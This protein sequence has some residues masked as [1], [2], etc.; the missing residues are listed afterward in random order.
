MT[1]KWGAQAGRRGVTLFSAFTLAVA[2][3]LTGAVTILSPEAAA[4]TADNRQITAVDSTPAKQTYTWTYDS[5]EKLHGTD[6][7]AMVRTNV[8]YTFGGTYVSSKMKDTAFVTVGDTL[9]MNTSTVGPQTN[10]TPLSE[11]GA[12]GSLLGWYMPSEASGMTVTQPDGYWSP[13]MATPDYSGTGITSSTKAGIPI[14][15]LTGIDSDGNTIVGSVMLDTAKPTVDFAY[16]DVNG[17][18]VT[19]DQ[20]AALCADD[21]WATNDTSQWRNVDGAIAANTT[22]STG[23]A[24]TAD[25][26]YNGEH[27]VPTSGSDHPSTLW[28]A[29]CQG[30]LVASLTWQ[31]TVATDPTKFGLTDATAPGLSMN[32]GISP[33]AKK[34]FGDALAA[35]SSSTNTQDAD[36]SQINGY[37]SALE[38]K[39]ELIKQVCADYKDG[40]PTC[41]Q[42]SPTGWVVDGTAGDNNGDNGVITGVGSG[43]EQGTVPEGV[44][45]LLWRVI[46]KNTGNLPLQNVRVAQDLINIEPAS[47]KTAPT[48]QKNSCV[49]ASL[50][51]SNGWLNNGAT[52]TITCTTTLDGP[53]SGTVQNTAA[54]NADVPHRLTGD[55]ARWI[56]T[57]DSKGEPTILDNDPAVEWFADRFTGYAD[58]NGTGAGV[59]GSIASNID[60]AQVEALNADL[61]LTKYV[62]STG[63]GCTVPEQGT[64][65]FNA[66]AGITGSGTSV[67]PVAGKDQATSGPHWVK[68]TSVAY[69]TDAQWLVIATNIGNTSLDHILLTD[70]RNLP[71]NDP[72]AG[73]GSTTAISEYEG[74]LAPGQSAVYNFTTRDITNINAT[75]SGNDG[76]VQGSSA[77]PTYFVGASGN[78][79]PTRAADV[80][81]SASAKADAMVVTVNPDNTTTNTP[82]YGLDGKQ[83]S[84]TSNSSNAEVNAQLPAP[85]LKET[86]WVC[87]LPAGCADPTADELAIM[88]G[89]FNKDADP[90]SADYGAAV[91]ANGWAKEA[92]LP[93]DQTAQWLIVVKNV[94]DTVI[95]NIRISDDQLTG[96]SATAVEGLTPESLRWLVPGQAGFFR[97]T[98][99]HITN[100]EPSVTG[101]SSTTDG[102]AAWHEPTYA[103]GKDVV[104]T[105]TAQGRAATLLGDGAGQYT[106]PIPEPVIPGDPN[107]N[108]DTFWMVGSNSSNAEVNTEAVA[109]DLKL[110][111][112]VCQKGTGCALPTGAD[113]DTLA[114][115][116]RAADGSISVVKG[117]TALG[118]VEETSVPYN[119]GAQWLVIVTNTGNTYLS[120][121]SV[122]DTLSGIAS[123]DLSIALTPTDSS[124]LRL[125]APGA[126]T[127]LQASTGNITNTASYET[128]DDGLPQGSSAEPTR[129]TGNDVVNVAQASGHVANSAGSNLDDPSKPG[130]SDPWSIDSNKSKAEVNA[131]PIT[132]GVDIEKCNDIAACK[133]GSASDHDSLE[134]AAQLAVNA[135][136]SIRFTITNKGTE[137]LTNVVVSDQ[138]T[139]GQAAD[140]KLKDLSCDFSKADPT[141]PTSGLRWDGGA[142]GFMP[143]ATFDCTGTLRGLPGEYIHED[144][145]SVTGLGKMTAQPVEDTD[146]WVGKTPD[147]PAIDI[148]KW[149]KLGEDNAITGDYD[150]VD[151]AK[152]LVAGEATPIRFTITNTGGEALRDIVVTDQTIN[153]TAGTVD[154]VSCD[155]SS[156]DPTAPQS[157]LTWDGGTK[158]FVAGASFTCTGVLTALDDNQLHSDNATVA[159]V[160][161]TSGEKVNDEDPWHGKT[162][163]HPS[164]DLVKY[165]TSC[166]DPA[167][168]STCQTTPEDQ[169]NGDHN[170][171]AVFVKPGDVTPIAFDFTNNGQDNL[172]NITLTDTTTNGAGQ[173]ENIA[174]DF[175][176][177]K[178]STGAAGPKAATSWL[179]PYDAEQDTIVD[180]NTN[181]TVDNPDYPANPSFGL[182]VG[183]KVSCVGTLTLQAGDIHEDTATISATGV[184]SGEPVKD[185]DPWKGESVTPTIELQKYDT[186]CVT[187]D[188]GECVLDEAGQ[189]TS[190]GVRS[191]D[192]FDFTG[193]FDE[194][195]AP[196]M[197][198]ADTDIPISMTIRNNGTLTL[199]NIVVTDETTDGLGQVQDLT[200]DFTNLDIN[201]RP[202]DPAYPA[203]SWTGPFKPGDEFVCSG[204]LAEGDGPGIPQ[205]Q[206]HSD[207]AS[208][209]GFA[210]KGKGTTEDPYQP[211]KDK[212]VHADDPWNAQTP[213]EPDIDL[214]K[215]DTLNGDGSK[216]EDG[217]ID[218][219]KGD[220]DN[221]AKP[222]VPN[223]PTPISFDI[224]NTGSEPLFDIKLDEVTTT[225]GAK[226][227]DLTCDFSAYKDSTGAVGPKITDGAA[228]DTDAKAD[229]KLEWN[230]PYDPEQDTIVDPNTHETVDNPNYP[231]NPVFGL[232]PGDKVTCTGTLDGLAP[233][234]LH[235]DNAT[236]T[237]TGFG[238]GD[239]VTDEDPWEADSEDKPGIDIEKYDTLDGDNIITGDYDFESS[240]K[241]LATDK[242]TPIEFEITNDGPEALVDIR[243]SDLTTIGDVK[244][245][246]LTCDFSKLGGPTAS[247]SWAEGPFNP[248]DSFKCKAT[249][250]GLAANSVHADTAT[251]TGVGQG[252]GLPVKAEDPW[253][254]TTEPPTEPTTEA[255]SASLALTKWVCAQGM[256]CSAPS[257]ADLAKLAAGQAAG[258]WVK[259]TTVKYNNDAEWLLVVTNTGQSGL[260]DVKVSMESLSGGGSGDLTG[261]KVSDTVI[262]SLGV[263]NSAAF[264]GC[265]APKVTNTGNYVVGQETGSDV[266]NTAQVSGVPTDPK[267]GAILDNPSGADQ[268][269]LYSNTDTAEVNTLLTNNPPTETPRIS[270]EKFDTLDK[271]DI[272]TG[273]YDD[274]NNPKVVKPGQKVPISFEVTNNGTEDLINVALSDTTINGT[275]GKV[276]NISCDFSKL[277]GPSTGTSWAGP[278]TVGSKF[279]C[280]GTLTALKNGQRHSDLVTVSATGKA[281][282]LTV[283]AHDPWH[284]RTPGANAATGG[285]AVVSVSTGWVI[286][287]LAGAAVVIA[288]AAL[289]LLRRRRHN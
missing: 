104:N 245:E 196:K 78:T 108:G 17:N 255:Y 115:V 77:E 143:G 67:V 244:L 91:T 265:V 220:F 123:T 102:N 170:G 95:D 177:Y 286:V 81:N 283:G 72:A 185:E 142:N 3:V 83:V 31:P 62:C 57:P 121:V 87:T 107:L 47:G 130:S 206:I 76:K 61:K 260:R 187:D 178:D 275:A 56:V 202:S 93:Y 192:S 172:Y 166:E 46:A 126:S 98:S 71:A 156:A 259:E 262:P 133:D 250:P 217:T 90:I 188:Q 238:S 208:V 140:D 147:G 252:S 106:L 12:K 21:S 232:Q 209:D 279:S 251:V 39:L 105:A 122:T 173:V 226:V 234:A 52:A 29:W 180:P 162:P 14:Y 271:D 135:P 6:I 222:V 99:S 225:G 36:I 266:V 132:P 268:W 59:Q 155:F 181:Q 152:S 151:S 114:G 30:V 111:K 235:V 84:V 278:F 32:I 258:G 141:A 218:E 199:M 33:E 231:V 110:T 101:T 237:A 233:G 27:G 179:D 38:P 160:G 282:G 203:T 184:L 9:V 176:A 73:H 280:S 118:W 53:F 273:D 256:G 246:G 26:E 229:G 79:D 94:G 204:T 54:L 288:G 175:S 69:Q 92:T 129:A 4:A 116:K 85:M 25:N 257:A 241:E 161:F 120:D 63:T 103:V 213:K 86:K 197:I 50:V 45:T 66:L 264:L 249:L 137:P 243:V 195:D 150:Y 219:S 169:Q 1:R 214:E 190:E 20:K 240:P 70:E 58:N 117:L 68:E 51:G 5:N 113:L 24:I 201:A 15:G 272:K 183:A 138:V 207:T 55:D 13:M 43:V 157:G 16:Y 254:G 11:N 287:Y 41:T 270:V 216:N 205:N 64:A 164:I 230:D 210:V 165:N 149:D 224:V 186:F 253:N 154:G 19:K 96:H 148:E 261:C 145:S 2:T 174:C 48:I 269:L 35:I 227:Q 23:R 139:T 131:L 153:S 221:T 248:G 125:L 239:N 89:S 191:E 75:A 44:T 124:A 284:G 247:T 74:I 119:T 28:N 274:I 65:E 212:P 97:A 168:V 167:D 194:K 182:P 198:P 144:L 88:G 277:G 10:G 40:K 82:V 193:D 8:A 60:S 7:G 34:E 215:Y 127:T 200:C 22:V 146:P 211:D 285:Q 112:W 267:T 171:D 276:E 236:V 18:L 49:N 109:P 289:L 42:D 242:E 163:P 158:G 223:T 263:G 80:V 37:M 136:V 228:S 189:P 128:G 159:G 281:S 134:D 100:T